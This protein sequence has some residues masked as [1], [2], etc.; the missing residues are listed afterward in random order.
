MTFVYIH[1]PILT[2]EPFLH[3][4]REQ[5]GTWLLLYSY[6]ASHENGGRIK[7]CRNWA[8]STWNKITGGDTP[9]ECPIWLWH[10]DDLVVVGYDRKNEAL[11]QKKRKGGIKG[12]KRRWNI[13]PEITHKLTES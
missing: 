1:I 10:D 4:S 5:I 13:S 8:P 11:A 6:C 3:A 2:S 12:A 9:S 7:N